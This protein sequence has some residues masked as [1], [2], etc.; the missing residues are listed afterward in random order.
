MTDFFT[1]N[2]SRI[3]DEL[4]EFLRIPSVSAKSDHNAD[5]KRCAEWLAGQFRSAGLEAQI[6]PTKGHPIV[7]A[8]NRHQPGRHAP[9]RWRS[10]GRS[11]RR[12]RQ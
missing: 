10:R 9:R 6:H 2:K 11:G 4:F 8:R 1:A 12:Q 3:R 5:T 7:L